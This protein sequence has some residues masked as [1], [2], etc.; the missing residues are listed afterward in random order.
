MN[1]FVSLQVPTVQQDISQAAIHI[2]HGIFGKR[3]KLHESQDD[4]ISH[5]S[6]TYNIQ[7]TCIL[8]LSASTVL[9]NFFSLPA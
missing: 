9:S 8:L 4:T 3:D 6:V 7:R 2:D 1:A 5:N